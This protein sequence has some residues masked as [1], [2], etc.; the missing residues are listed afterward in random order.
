MPYTSQSEGKPSATPQADPKAEPSVMDVSTPAVKDPVPAS[1]AQVVAAPV[2]DSAL[3]VSSCDDSVRS[4]S[5]SIEALSSPSSAFSPVAP[6][7]STDG[8]SLVSQRGYADLLACAA[9]ASDFVSSDK[10]LMRDVL[11]KRREVSVGLKPIRKGSAAAVAS[12]GPELDGLSE[13]GARFIGN[14]KATGIQLNKK[15]VGQVRMSVEGFESKCRIQ[16]RAHLIRRMNAKS[17]Q[18]LRLSRHCGSRK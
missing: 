16:V 4:D 5:A 12:P 17:E 1:A 13:F 15:K 10:R 3:P 14:L 8:G 2:L 7:F 18:T 11:D 9:G 6:S